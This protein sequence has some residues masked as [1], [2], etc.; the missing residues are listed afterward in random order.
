MSRYAI[1]LALSRVGLYSFG[2]IPEDHR[3]RVLQTVRDPRLPEL[4]KLTA[5]L[6]KF[7][8]NWTTVVPLVEMLFVP[9]TDSELGGNPTEDIQRDCQCACLDIA[10]TGL[11][12]EMARDRNRRLACQ[13]GLLEYV[14][15]LPWGIPRVDWKDRLRAV[16]S[17]FKVE[18]GP[19]PVPRLS[20]IAKSTL[21][22]T[23]REF[24]MEFRKQL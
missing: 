15:C 19:L 23:N 6:E 17:M 5:S 1:C 18:L 20:T 13:Q 4:A 9:L 14:V 11:Q 12:A 7:Q 8:Y 10:I 21:A 22:R 3:A 24:S 16:V 2:A